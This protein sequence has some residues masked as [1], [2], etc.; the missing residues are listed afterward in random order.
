MEHYKTSLYSILQC[1]L[2]P[3]WTQYLT[4]L[5]AVLARIAPV[6]LEVH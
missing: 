4:S 2:S 1:E 3:A 6:P 5:H